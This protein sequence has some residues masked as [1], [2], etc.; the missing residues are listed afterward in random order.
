MTRDQLVRMENDVVRA[1]VRALEMAHP[2]LEGHSER[3]AT[4]A[5]AIGC[6]LGLS[7]PTLRLLRIA[8]ALHDI[9]ML[10]LP[11]P[12]LTR[13]N[14]TPEEWEQIRSHPT[15]SVQLLRR[16][17]RFKDALVWVECHHERWDGRGYP[18]GWREEQIPLPA[19][20]LAVA[21]AFDGM[22]TPMPYR[23]ALSEQEA[24]ELI[25]QGAA[26]QFDPRVVKAL[27]KVQPVIQPVGRE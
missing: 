9:G 20:I 10:A 4:Y 14:P 13:A 12:L 6:E 16:I 18:F 24:L 15:L 5:V 11:T 2:H 1:L 21:E 27:L 26:M 22:R 7:K 17:H 19:R 3:V 23:D 8:G 25:Q